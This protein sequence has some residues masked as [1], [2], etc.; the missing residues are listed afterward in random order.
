MVLRLQI[1]GV[2]VEDFPPPR[3]EEGV[4]TFARLAD[5]GV[6]LVEREA[7]LEDEEDV[8]RELGVRRVAAGA[9]RDQAHNP[10]Y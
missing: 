10:R 7:V 2:F 4:E 5:V 6:V 9:E 8:G 1:V 3:L